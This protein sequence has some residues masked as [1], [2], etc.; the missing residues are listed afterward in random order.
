[1]NT[2]GSV[3]S[4]KTLTQTERIRA[5][6]QGPDGSLYAATD[7]KSGGDEIWKFTPQ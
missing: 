7:G 4:N 1:L 5:V 3:A 6:V 2:D